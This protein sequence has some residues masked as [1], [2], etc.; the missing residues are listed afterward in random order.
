MNR[1]P[2]S[3][4]KHWRLIILLVIC[5]AISVIRHKKQNAKKTR[6]K[7]RAK[8]KKMTVYASYKMRFTRKIGELMKTLVEK[9]SNP[10][11]LKIK[12][13]VGAVLMAAAVIVPPV[14]IFVTDKKLLADPSVLGVVAIGMLFFG[15]VG[16]FGFIR[17]YRLYNKLPAVLAETD[18]EFLYIHANK[19]AKIPLAELTEAHADITLPH[20]FEKDFLRELL[21]HIFTEEYG[22]ITLDL[23]EYGTYKMRFVSHVQATT[24]ELIRF[25]DEAMNRA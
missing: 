23:S 3:Q 2:S 21:I 19:E 24:N 22:D 7:N 20:M 14:G 25:L 11:L 13:I 18:G 9:I 4:K 12:L 1:N 10:I 8:Q 15:L 17:P 16:V 6:S 5:I